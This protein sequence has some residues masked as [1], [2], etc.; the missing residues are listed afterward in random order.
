MSYAPKDIFIFNYYRKRSETKILSDLP[1]KLYF[2][3]TT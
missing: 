1:L 3:D 2:L